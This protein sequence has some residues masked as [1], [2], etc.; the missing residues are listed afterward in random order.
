[1]HMN[2][3]RS[4]IEIIADILRIGQANKTP[5][6][7]RVGMSHAQLHRY[8]DYLVERGFVVSDS[9]AYPGATAYRVSQDG[10]L[11]LRSIESVEGLLISDDEAALSESISESLAVSR[12]SRGKGYRLHKPNRNL[13]VSLI[14][15]ASTRKS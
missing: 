14:R 5:I 3:R 6:M 7:Y 1:M 13:G 12:S 4:N 11:L 15:K 8:L 9:H 2:R 10:K